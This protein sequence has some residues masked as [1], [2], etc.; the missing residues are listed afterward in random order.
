MPVQVIHARDLA[1]WIVRLAESGTTGVFNATGP[2]TPHRFDEVLAACAAGAAADP[3]ITWVDER[4]LIEKK[5]APW[6][7][8]PLW[9]P[10]GEGY[11]GL[12]AVDVS[13]AVGAGLAFRPLAQTCA[14]TLDWDRSRDGAGMS[15]Q[16][17]SDREA[18]L[19][20][21]WKER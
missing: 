5:V 16:L 7:E 12:S 2:A 19:L 10:A 6:M 21:A 20:A 18:E 8:L 11:D 1:D 15:A 17:S 13:R 14:E 9:L 4:W 3:A